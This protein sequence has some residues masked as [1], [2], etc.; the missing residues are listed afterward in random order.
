MFSDI[1]FDFTFPIIC[2]KKKW[3]PSGVQGPVI[4]DQLDSTVECQDF[5]N[6][7]TKVTVTKV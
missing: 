5:I 7:V 1:D 3:L 4:F 6:V 2:K